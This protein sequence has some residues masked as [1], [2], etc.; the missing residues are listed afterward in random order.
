MSVLATDNFNRADGG[1]GTN[2][3]TV[4]SSGAPQISTNV[5]R[6][7]AVGTDS[8]S[9]YN[10]TSAPNDQYASSAV[11]T[12]TTSSVGNGPIV[13]TDSGTKTF[14]VA[15]V[16]GPLDATAKIFLSKFTSGTSVN[17]TNGTFT[18]AAND[19]LKLEVIGTNLSV[20]LNGV[21]K[22]G[23]TSDGA[24]STGQFGIQVF[25]DAGTTADSQL[26]N[27]EGGDTGSVIP[28]PLIFTYGVD[29]VIQLW[30][31]VGLY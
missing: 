25:A 6:S 7:T 20:Y 23:P 27:W 3:T 30:D 21:L 4:T 26:D 14:Y 31:W 12:A 11:V 29:P 16:T 13:R 17:I 5:V 8:M 2:W 19:V 24:I 1:L 10:A 22:I 18:V 15:Y 9:Y 28:W